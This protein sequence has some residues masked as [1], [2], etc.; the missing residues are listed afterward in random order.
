[1]NLEL[2]RSTKDVLGRIAGMA[3]LYS[4]RFS[5]QMTVVA[6]HRVTDVIE[7][8]GLTCAPAVFQE[9]CK[10]FVKY[11]DVVSLGQQ[12]D[13]CASGADLGGTLSITFDDGYADNVEVAAPILRKLKLPAS[14][15]VT[16]GFVDSPI[17]APW[18]A[19]LRAGVD[20]MTWEQVRKLRDM[21]FEIGNHTDTHID[22][23]T[24]EPSVV[25]SELARSKAKLLAELGVD[26][27]LFAYPFGGRQNISPV[28]RELVREAGFSCC[29]SCFGGVNGR[30]P[31]PFM[32]NR[33][34]IAEWF[35][36]PNQFGYELLRGRA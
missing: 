4:R 26:T 11:F 2:R 31:D 29:L 18:D 27:R 5:S 17:V 23:G 22:L 24:T 25:R 28:S 13:A 12:V 19:Q 1:M 20:W 16:S 14:F 36:S 15:F 33:I 35:A 21:G 8:D 34:G 6:F 7:T 32:L 3:G 10:F 30:H 9:F